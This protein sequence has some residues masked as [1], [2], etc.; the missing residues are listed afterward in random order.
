VA[1]VLFACFIQ[2]A[3]AVVPVDPGDY[4]RLPG[5]ADMLLTYYQ[6]L[7]ADDLYV[8]GD[9]ALDNL[10]LKLDIGVIRYLHYFAVGDWLIVP[11]IIL[12]F[13]LQDI[14]LTDKTLSGVG[15][16]IFGTTF[17]PLIDPRNL[18]Q[19]GFTLWFTAP[20]GAETN[21]GFALSNNRW[22]FEF[23][24][25]HSWRFAPKWTLDLVADLETYQD[26]HGTGLR[27][28]LVFQADAM[29]RYHLS[30]ATHVAATYRHVWGVEKRCSMAWCG[31]AIS[32]IT[33]S[34]LPGPRF[35][36]SSGSCNCSGGGT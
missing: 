23:Q 16:L 13:G 4:T 6:H 17:S 10:D 1:G 34:Y 9:K 7:T 12:P 32:T 28:D 21:Q 36:P 8:N 22:T 15:D 29:V 26:Q 5:G 30:D 27:K 35:F 2:P 3:L 24:A 25:A 14:G 19:F 18:R 11:D 31:Q 20:T 33:L